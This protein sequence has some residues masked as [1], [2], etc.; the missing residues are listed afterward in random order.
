MAGEAAGP[1]F[2]DQVVG[3]EAAQQSAEPGGWQHGEAGRGGQGDVGG[4]RLGEPAE[5]PGGVRVQG[6]VGGGEHGA[7]VRGRLAGLQGVEPGG[8]ARAGR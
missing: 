8:G 7:Y 4:G 6:E 5:D 1:V 3:L 2:L